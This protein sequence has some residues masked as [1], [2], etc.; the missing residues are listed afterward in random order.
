MGAGRASG[1]AEGS[2]RVRGVQMH[3]VILGSLPAP[4]PSPPG[5]LGAGPEATY[6]V[7]TCAFLHT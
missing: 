7:Q 2:R 5:S 1:A 3:L 4:A 6:V